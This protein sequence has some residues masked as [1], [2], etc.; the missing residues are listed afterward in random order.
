V[1]LKVDVEEGNT[2]EVTGHALFFLTRGDSA[3]IPAELI[4]RGFRPDSLRWWI[5]RWR[6]QTSPTAMVWSR[7]AS[8]PPRPRR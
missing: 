2:L 1:E 5:D 8:G 4:A 3:V 6:N 7:A